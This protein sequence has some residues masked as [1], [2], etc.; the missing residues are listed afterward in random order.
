MPSIT[1][2]KYTVYSNI[3]LVIATEIYAQDEEEAYATAQMELDD[4]LA[5][6]N[7]HMSMDHVGGDVV[8]PKVCDFFI[9]VDDVL[10]SDESLRD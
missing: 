5:I 6:K 3:S 8:T 9:N 1:K 4:M 7:V 2:N 10:E